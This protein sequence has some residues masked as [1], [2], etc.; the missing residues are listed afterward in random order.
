[1]PSIPRP[2]AEAAQHGNA[3]G[4]LLL[5]VII[6]VVVI[7]VWRGSVARNP[8]T[9]CSTCKGRGRHYGWLFPRNF[10]KCGDCGGTGREPRRSAKDPEW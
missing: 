8:W 5:L 2:L 1:M 7:G 10:H 4:G 6:A 9:A 3:A